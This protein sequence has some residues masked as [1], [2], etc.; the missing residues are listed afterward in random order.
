MYSYKFQRLRPVYTLVGDPL[1]KNISARNISV[2]AKRRFVAASL[3][4]FATLAASAQYVDITDPL[5][6]T[7]EAFT[8]KEI[9][10]STACFSEPLK[11]LQLNVS[12]QRI[13]I[14]LIGVPGDDDF[15]CF[16]TA[17]PIL[18]PGL[19]AGTYDLNGYNPDSKRFE[20]LL[21]Q[22]T[23]N[24]APPRVTINSLAY[25][26]PLRNPI[27]IGAQPKLRY[28]LTPDAND[29]PPLLALNGN[30]NVQN[31]IW[32]IADAGFKA[33]PAAGSAPA[34]ALPVC[35]FFSPAI[36]S[37]FYSI[38][39]EDCALLRSLPTLWTD[40]GIAFRILP[41]AG[42]VCGFGTQAVYRLYS[43]EHKNHRYTTEVETYRSM[44]FE[45]WS[46]EGAA[47]CAP[48]D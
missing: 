35:R 8:G 28:F 24:V 21:R 37:H 23:V 11:M 47:F 30:N 6:L 25:S 43:S 7:A 20:S 46:G 2:M 45:G 40:E 15:N 32:R 16:G 19:P 38:R 3:A 33:W 17:K 41:A 27:V 39:P 1:L 4:T 9:N 18:I 13:D 44:Q 10:V 34:A 14:R 26:Q 5:P 42:G 36:S 48:V 31:P 12:S 29:I 22:L